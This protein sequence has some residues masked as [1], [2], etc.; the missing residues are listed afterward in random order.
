MTP[1]F[2]LDVNILVAMMWPAHEAHGRVQEWFRKHGRKAW[3]TCP[4]TQAGF[5]RIASNPA[6]SPDAVTPQDAAALL[7]SNLKHPS[8]EFW[9]DDISFVDAVASFQKELFGHRQ[10]TD[11]YLLGLVMRKKG[12]LVTLDK[13]V[14]TLLP[15]RTLQQQYVVT[16]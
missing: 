5:V 16:L 4:L 8:H 11:A 12:K 3:A 9:G 6:F 13:G 2:L 10:V 1:T 15:D 7:D 14:A